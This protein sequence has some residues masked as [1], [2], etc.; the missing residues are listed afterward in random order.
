MPVFSRF[1]S[2]RGLGRPAIAWVLGVAALA[3][4]G[5]CLAEP[6]PA[7]GRSVDEWLARMHAAS[8]QHSFIGTFVVSSPAGAL[9]SGRIWHAS[10]GERPTERIESLTGA[11]RSTLRR[12]DQ[13]L[14]LM[15]DQRLARLERRQPAGLFPAGLSRSREAARA[16]YYT[17]REAGADRVAGFDADLVLIEP[18]DNHRY[19]YRVWSE[20]KS[21][22]VVKLQTLD[23]QG[24]V[25]EQAVFS[26]LQ[27]DA[28]L[29]PR[30]V[31]PTL[32]P[33]AGWRVE[34]IE[35]AAT[36]AQAEGWDLRSPVPGFEAV[37]CY[38]RGPDAGDTL[39]CVFSDGLASVSLFV[40]AYDPQRHA[41]VQAAVA[42]GASQ[43]QGRRLKSWW[44]TAVGE[45]PPQ[46]LRAFAQAL[47]RRQ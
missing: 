30:Q 17:A 11:A 3:G 27:I 46:T 42:V 36:T 25:L 13:W 4:P 24:Q 41:A 5:V 7:A 43:T 18:R 6:R 35:N 33:P 32:D 22:L 12:G 34:R 10:E 39:Q 38:R 14:T 16:S 2:Y 28:A 26:Q 29:R 45:V 8:R 23:G 9:S 37:G 20:R 19:G 40:E 21:G 1:L 47:E 15:P 31:V 44:V